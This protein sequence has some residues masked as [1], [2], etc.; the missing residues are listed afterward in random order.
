MTIWGFRKEMEG[1]NTGFL[2]FDYLGLFMYL[3]LRLGKVLGICFIATWGSLGL[4]FARG[5]REK[6]TGFVW[7]YFLLALCS[8]RVGVSCDVICSIDV[9][10]TI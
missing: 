2:S 8:S 5:E 3:Q 6:K 1:K 4:L 7:V 10:A 9:V